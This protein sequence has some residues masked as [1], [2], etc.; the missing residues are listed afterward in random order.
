MTTDK[1]GASTIRPSPTLMRKVHAD[2]HAEVYREAID[3][4]IRITLSGILIVDIVD[5]VWNSFDYFKKYILWYD[6]FYY[7]RTLKY[8]IYF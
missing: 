8:N 7:Y 5:F 1:V 2:E 4:Y 6:L 3:T